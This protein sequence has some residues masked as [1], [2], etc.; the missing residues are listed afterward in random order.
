MKFQKFNEWLEAK[1]VLGDLGHSHNPAAPRMGR[2]N[3]QLVMSEPDDGS[4]DDQKVLA[5]FKFT[6]ERDG[7]MSNPST[8][9]AVKLMYQ[10]S[11]Q[12]HPHLMGKIREMIAAHQKAAAAAPK[13]VNMAGQG[14]IPKASWSKNA[15]QIG[16]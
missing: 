9:Q 14:A 4:A 5:A 2:N 13:S 11:A 1:T 3:A 12:N 6:I 8:L 10:N 7:G 15:P 16:V